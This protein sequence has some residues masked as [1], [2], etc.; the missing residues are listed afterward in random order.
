MKPLIRLVFVNVS[1]FF[2]VRTIY[3]L[4]FALEYPS[5][6]YFY[7]E[8]LPYFWL[9]SI[10]SVLAFSWLKVAVLFLTDFPKPKVKCIGI[11]VIS[12][13]ICMY[14]VFSTVY[15]T[16][17]YH[18]QQD[19]MLAAR[20]QNNLWLCLCIIFVTYSGVKLAS[21]VEVYLN[22]NYGRRIRF[23]MWTAVLCLALR[24][25][26]NTLLLVLTHDLAKWKKADGGQGHTAF[27][28][29]D[30]L[31]TEVAFLFFLIYAIQVPV[32]KAASSHQEESYVSQETERDISQRISM[33][34]M[35]AE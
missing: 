35:A 22:S 5:V 24:I 1:A 34:L 28:I 19:L 23:M 14:V 17:W 32:R 27:S 29:I 20:I 2:L 18:T 26:I 25:V 31:V 7:L 33:R 8:L 9:I 15:F 13:N 11:G 16:T 30:Y 12:L 10:C 4:D 6:L 21:I 3:W